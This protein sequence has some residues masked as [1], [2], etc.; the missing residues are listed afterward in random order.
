MDSNFKQKNAIEFWTLMGP[1]VSQSFESHRPINL[2]LNAT[3]PITVKEGENPG[4]I[5]TMSLHHCKK[6]YF[7][8]KKNTFFQ[9]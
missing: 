6:I 7:D 5:P 4:Y 3:E 9:E 1:S 8:E 2:K